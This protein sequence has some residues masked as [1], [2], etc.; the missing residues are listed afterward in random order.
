MSQSI[1]P[2]ALL[3]AS[4]PKPAPTITTAYDLY[5]AA[6]SVSP[7]SPAS[8]QPVIVQDAVSAPDGRETT[9]QQAP[10]QTAARMPLVPARRTHYIADIQTRH[11]AALR[12][13]ASLPRPPMM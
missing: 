2:Y 7:A 5:S 8:S 11:N 6:Q 9:S 4:K 13:T 1:S 12:R 10:L 3:R